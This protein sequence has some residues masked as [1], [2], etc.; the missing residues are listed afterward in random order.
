MSIL[1]KKLSAAVAKGFCVVNNDLLI[2]KTG[3]RL[4]GTA[5]ILVRI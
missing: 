3:Y 5:G 1:V 2:M 4:F